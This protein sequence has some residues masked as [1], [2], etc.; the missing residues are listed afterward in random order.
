MT[1]KGILFIHT[2]VFTL[3]VMASLGSPFIAIHYPK[4]F[5]LK[6]I[7]II[8][9]SGILVILSWPIFGDFPF[10]VWENKK[11]E[12][13]VSGSSYRGSC[14][15][16]YLKAWFGVRIPRNLVTA[17]LIFLLLLPILSGLFLT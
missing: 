7:V 10:T 15:S 17:I 3:F 4:F 8:A 1:S 16:H 5:S 12:S 11:R 2:T 6:K 9:I 13:E 14:I